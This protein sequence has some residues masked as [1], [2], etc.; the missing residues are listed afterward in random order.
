MFSAAW[1]H[2]D[3]AHMLLQNGADIN[4]INSEG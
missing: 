2:I 4:A 3:I 1:G